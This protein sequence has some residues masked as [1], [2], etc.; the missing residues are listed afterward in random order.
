MYV[1]VAI[2]FLGHYYASCG[3]FVKVVSCN[4]ALR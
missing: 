1:E 3:V 2:T 4:T